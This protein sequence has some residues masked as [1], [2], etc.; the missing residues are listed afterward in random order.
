MHLGIWG[1]DVVRVFDFAE[2]K[3]GLDEEDQVLDVWKLTE[4][5]EKDTEK[6]HV[7]HLQFV[8]MEK[9]QPVICSV[10]SGL[11]EKKF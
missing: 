9:M 2:Y 4:N 7:L 5:A 10:L 1:E 11:Y 6:M 8:L 3:I